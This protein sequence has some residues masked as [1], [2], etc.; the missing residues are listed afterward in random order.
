MT[1]DHGSVEPV[2]ASESTAQHD[3]LEHWL[4]DIRT[5]LADDPPDWLD[6]TSDGTS[7][8]ASTSDGAEARTIGRHRAED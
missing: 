7:D 4:H 5:D 3:D 1:S 6:T 8:T 2:D